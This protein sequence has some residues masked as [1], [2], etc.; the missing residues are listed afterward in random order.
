M[1]RLPS[2]TLRECGHPGS[3]AQRHRQPKTKPH[4]WVRC[5][6]ENGRKQDE[7]AINWKPDGSCALPGPLEAVAFHLHLA[8]FESAPEVGALPSA[9]ITR[10]QLSYDPVR[11]PLIPPP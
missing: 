7:T 2:N 10:L 8:F 1:V 11:L 4:G 6:L 3:A 9:S 5:S